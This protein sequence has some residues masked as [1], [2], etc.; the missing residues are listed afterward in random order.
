MGV[1]F[2]CTYIFGQGCLSWW[3]GHAHIHVKADVSSVSIRK[4][5][6]AVFRSCGGM[7]ST[8]LGLEGVVERSEGYMPLGE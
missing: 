2:Q 5:V 6:S 4:S 3:W 1:E 7:R 8:G